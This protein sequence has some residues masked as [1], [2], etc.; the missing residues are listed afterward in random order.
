MRPVLVGW[1][2]SQLMGLTSVDW[3]HLQLMGSILAVRPVS[4]AGAYLRQWDLSQFV[5]PFSVGGAY[6]RWW[7]LS[8]LVGPISDGRG[9]PQLVG[10]ISDGR[11][12]PQ[13]VGPI[14][15]GRV[16]LSW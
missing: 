12:L 3:T 7:G 1:A 8:Q 9:L 13:L 14:S 10:P 2:P 16:C 5:R 15:D 4:V 11:G 6:L